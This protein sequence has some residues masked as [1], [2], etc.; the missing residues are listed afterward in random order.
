MVC[1]KRPTILFKRTI[2]GEEQKF[3]ACAACRDRKDCNFFLKQGDEWTS[4]K[5]AHWD[6]RRKH[7]LPSIDRRQLSERL[8]KI[9]KI[10]SKDRS[11]CHS[12]NLLLTSEERSSH[13]D[14]DVTDK[15]SDYQLSHPSEIMKPL[16]S[17]KKEAQYLFAKRSTQAIVNM[18][19]SAGIRSVLCIGAPRIH[20]FV[21]ATH[22]SDMKSLLLDFDHRYHQF[23]GDKEFSWFNAFNC[24]WF[25]EDEG[26]TSTLEFMRQAGENELA[27][28][29]DPPFGG[30]AEPLV[31][32]FQRLDVFH[33]ELH[34][35]RNGALSLMWIFPYFMEPMILDSNPSMSML[36]YKVDYDNHP[37]FQ[38][39]HKGRKYGS[40]VRIFTNILPSK[41]PLPEEEGYRF[42]DFCEKWVSSE[43]KHCFKCSSCTSKDG[44]TYVH[45]DRCARCVKPSWKHCK[46]CKRCCLPDH[47]CGDFKPAGCFLCHKPGHK[48]NECPIRTNSEDADSANRQRVRKKIKVQSSSGEEGKT[49]GKHNFGKRKYQSNEKNI[50][51]RKV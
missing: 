42:C 13:A 26:K 7:I 32:T 6:T 5:Q 14:H 24:H 17:A 20:E 19:R 4:Q 47:K 9:R 25:L 23:Y 43:N 38:Q 3:Y 51:K 30:R 22:S 11:Y 12:C 34:P 37:L 27:I 40:P 45:C 10:Q 8:E 44:R 29:T 36:D 31:Y 49:M 16:E 18:L 21:R 1:S 50:K 15:I 28:V 39:G 35:D 41:L 2:D 33:K 48:K 46:E